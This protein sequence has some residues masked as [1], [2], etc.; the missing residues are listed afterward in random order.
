MRKLTVGIM[1]QPHLVSSDPLLSL[2]QSIDELAPTSLNPTTFA[3]LSSRSN[4]TQRSSLKSTTIASTSQASQSYLNDASYSR[5]RK[6]FSSYD[7]S[8]F[9]LNKTFGSLAFTYQSS[10]EG[11]GGAPKTLHQCPHCPYQS[12]KRQHLEYHIRRHT[13]EKPHACPHCTYR[14]AHESNMRRHVTLHH[15]ASSPGGF[16]ATPSSSQTSSEDATTS[17]ATNPAA[18][19][20]L[21][22]PLP[23]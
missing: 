11:R 12:P 6:T 9:S 3:G 14:A 17:A 22:A 7:L 18:T 21:A 20:S 16:M 8:S 2:C 19:S 4:S 23:T 1:A 15:R 13:G 5:H 10:L